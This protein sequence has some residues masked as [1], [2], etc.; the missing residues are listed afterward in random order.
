MASG[1][2][3]M[4]QGT[5]SNVGKSVLA[6]GLCR[7]LW[8]D[9]Y[10][11]APFKAQNMSNN[12]FVTPEGGEIGRAQA[13]QAAACKLPPHVDMNPILLK[14][15]AEARSQ[16]VVL[17]KAT[18][19]MS[20]RDYYRR[21][22]ELRPV[23][24]AALERLRAQYDVVVIEGAGSP[25][26]IN[27]RSV[28]L[29]NMGLAREVGAPVLLVGDIDRGGVFAHLYG[30]L[31]L[32]EPADRALVR[33]FVI[34][35][36]RGDKTILDPGI[37]AIVAKAGAPCLG[38]VPWVPN[39]GLPEEDSV[40]LTARGDLQRSAE[41]VLDIA[42]LKLPRISNFTDFEPLQA[43]PGVAL[44]YVEHAGELGSPDVIVIPGTKST[45]ADLWFLR[46]AGF[47]VALRRHARGGRLVFGVCGGLQ[48]LG[49]AIY[50]PLGV[51]SN[52]PEAEG[53]GLLPLETTFE[54]EKTTVEAEGVVLA[55]PGLLSPVRGVPVVGY[56]IHAGQSRLTG[57]AGPLLR[58][59]RRAGWPVDTVDGLINPEGTVAGTYLHGLFDSDPFRRAF[60]QAL[61]DRKGVVLPTETA[62]TPGDEV[63][64]LDRMA[65]VL[66]QHLDVAAIY[67]IAG[68]EA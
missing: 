67:R 10:R 18:E 2:L 55:A 23:T 41:A 13:V 36:F 49:T 46:D 11:V 47:A 7:L 57:E 4:L 54:R 14:P 26:E 58:L 12:S 17:G 9:G 59:T 29:V 52:E 32:L 45:I 63:D 68:L 66:R 31:E 60:L 38:V 39:H 8:Q 1:R 44:R 42:V 30:T 25:A 6:A 24:L 61:A 33:G 50:D 62:A 22:P 28:D 16:V 27:L 21:K 34:N 15:E 65:G 19:A 64:V 5:A 56:E 48:M 43:E 51:E 35:K 20:A 53:L 40:A 37:K 3:I